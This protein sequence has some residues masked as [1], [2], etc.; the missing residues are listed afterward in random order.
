MPKKYFTVREAERLLPKITEMLIKLINIRKAI[1][2]I[3]SIEVSFE[4]ED[5]E[6]ANVARSSKEFH[7]LNYEFY[8]TLDELHN[9]GCILKDLD[10]GIVDFYTKH[11]GRTVFLCWQ[12]GEESIRY[13]HENEHG[14]TGRQPVE[15][16]RARRNIEF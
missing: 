4:D 14:F 10:H 6:M 13:W 15:K 12:L 5:E 9:M 7:R 8:T 3:S 1:Y 2:T 11:K 16:L